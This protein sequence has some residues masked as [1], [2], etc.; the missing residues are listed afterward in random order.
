MN[1]ELFPCSGGMG[2]G[3]RRAGI[4]FDFAF[5]KDHDAVTSYTQNLG[6]RPVQMDV[7]DLLRMVAAGWRPGGGPIDLLVADPP[8][9]PWSRAGKRKGLDDERDCLAVTA[10][11]IRLLRPRAYLIGNVP[12]LQDSTS[13]HVVQDVIGGLAKQGYCVADYVSLDA[14][15]YSVP[16]HR[17]RPFWFGHLDGPCIRWPAPTHGAPTE[18]LAIGV[19]GLEPWITCRQALGHLPIA[20]LGRPVRM[21]IRPKGQDGR[22]NGGD[23]FRCSS[24][25]RPGATVVTKDSRK[26]G[27]ILIPGEVSA[28]KVRR[29][30]PNGRDTTLCSSPDA[31]AKVV[32]A[33]EGIKGGGILMPNEVVLFRKPKGRGAN[34]TG[35]KPAPAITTNDMSEGVTLMVESPFT[36][37][38]KH[39]VNRGA[40]PSYA[41]TTKGD[42]RGAQGACALEWPWDRPS[43]TIQGDERL[44]AVGHHDPKV[45]NSQHGPNA[46]ILSER[47]AAIL[48]GFPEGWLFAGET[49]KARWSQLGQAMPPPLAEAVARAVA[50]QMRALAQVRAIVGGV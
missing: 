48:Q 35:D 4:T 19:H 44:G 32:V 13:W 11:L 41:V 49:K 45:P 50:E 20:E 43:T 40:S 8:C 38:R 21:V 31:P 30:G 17:V 26:G 47:A 24:P 3:F 5:D 7:N 36:P 29:S 10:D 25:D 23:G 12:G 2:E 16:Q 28:P 15:D 22:K 46:I 33:H 39:P 9:T 42:G 1:I 34:A 37:N 14:A 6:H 27:Q 18:Q